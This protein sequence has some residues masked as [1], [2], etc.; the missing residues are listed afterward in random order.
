[1]E[2]P[3]QKETKLAT[4]SPDPKIT[5]LH[6]SG[7]GFDPFQLSFRAFLHE[8]KPQVKEVEKLSASMAKK[9]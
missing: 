3:S 9:F 6:T 8:S 2:T 1:M 5:R 4:K 7:F